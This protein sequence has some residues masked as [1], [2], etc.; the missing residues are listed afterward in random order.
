[1]KKTLLACALALSSAILATGSVQA[2]SA[3]S[4]ESSSASSQF[5]ASLARWVAANSESREL[6]KATSRIDD[7]CASS[8]AALASKFGSEES[9]ATTQAS[10]KALRAATQK[11]ARERALLAPRID[12]ARE[13]IQEEERRLQ[14]LRPLSA[15]G[16]M[17]EA[18]R[19][20][21]RAEDDS[22]PSIWSGS[23]YCESAASRLIQRLSPN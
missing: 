3:P 17:R 15:Y 14:T 7:E 2:E 22:Y 13:I 11:S 1:M 10:W 16:R 19:K 9:L 23:R 6:W 8:I 4:S 5:E 21:F 20:T 12:A 18:S